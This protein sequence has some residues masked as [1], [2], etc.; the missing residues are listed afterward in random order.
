MYFMTDIT[1]RIY[2]DIHC[3]YKTLIIKGKAMIPLLM[4]PV[5]STS[6]NADERK[7]TG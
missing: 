4:S 7:E 6:I 5:K 3:A 1:D 2:G